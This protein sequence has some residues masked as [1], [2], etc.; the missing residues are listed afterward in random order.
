ESCVQFH[1]APPWVKVE[2]FPQAYQMS[3]HPIC[4]EVPL[5]DYQVLFLAGSAGQDVFRPEIFIAEVIVSVRSMSQKQ[6]HT[7]F[8]VGAM[9][10][11]YFSNG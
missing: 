8:S 3:D 11:I 2:L 1:K 5:Y 10:W 7:I 4:Q 6:T 9:D